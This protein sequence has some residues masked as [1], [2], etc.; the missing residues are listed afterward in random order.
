MEHSVSNQ[1]TLHYAV[2]D[3]GLHI[4]PLSHKRD[5]SRIWVNYAKIKY[6]YFTDSDE[7]FKL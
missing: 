3:L 2:S 6:V 4:V 1:W 5:A 7:K